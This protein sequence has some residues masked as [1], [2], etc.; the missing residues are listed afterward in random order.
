MRH[1]FWL[2]ALL[3]PALAACSNHDCKLRVN[4]VCYDKQR[5]SDPPLTAKWQIFDADS[6][7]PLEGVWINFL[8]YGQADSRGYMPCV[9]AV[10]GR[11][12]QNGRFEAKAK[13]GSWRFGGQPPMLFKRDYQPLRFEFKGFQMD[14]ATAFVEVQ[15]YERDAYPAWFKRLE[16]LGYTAVGTEIPNGTVRY[17][18]KY[19][20]ALIKDA[21]NQAAYREGGRKEMWVTRR[22]LPDYAAAPGIGA[23]CK[24]PG[25]ENIGFDEATSRLLDHER[26]MHAYSYLCDPQWDSIPADFTRTRSPI[27]VRQSVWLVNDE[28]HPETRVR[29]LIPDYLAP[30]PNQ[31]AIPKWVAEESR[32]L[33][34]DERTKFCEW[35]APFA[36]QT[37]NVEP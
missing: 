34:P 13:D 3:L 21:M 4:G 35:L 11:T 23:E 33:R 8:W 25:A 18:K 31:F 2:I 9:G 37:I 19:S 1:W 28:E 30:G 27:F 6:G 7:K 32:A 29:D 12:D 15:H 14:E 16:D 17:E 20:T 5:S 24:N 22:T 26:A 36:Q 10:L